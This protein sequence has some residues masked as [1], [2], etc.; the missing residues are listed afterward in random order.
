MATTCGLARAASCLWGSDRYTFLIRKM[1]TSG[2][3]LF[4]FGVDEQ[5]PRDLASDSNSIWLITSE[6]RLKQYS[7]D[8]V[9]IDSIIDFFSSGW[10]LTW[11]NNH[12]WV[13]D[14]L[15]RTIYQIKIPLYQDITPDSVK[16]WIDSENNLV[17]LDVRELYEFESYGRIPH[18]INLPWNSGVLDT[19][20]TQLSVEDTIIVVCR[21]G[22][23]SKQA[24]NFLDGKGFQHVYNMLGGMDAWHYPV[25]AGGHISVDVIWEM[26]KSSFMVASDV[27]VDS[28]K[29]LTLQP[30][31]SM[32]FDGFFSLEVYGTLLAEGTADDSIHFV[33]TGSLRMGWEGIKMFEGSNSSLSYCGMEDSQ[34]GIICLNS[35]PTIL[36]S[37]ISGSQNSLY[38]SGQEATPFVDSC[39]LDG[40]GSGTFILI[41]CDSSSSPT[42]TNC[43]ILG[44]LKGVV[45]K[46]GADPQ[47]N[48]NNI[49][50]NVEYG[51]SNEDSTI[52]VDARYNWW[53]HESGPFDTSV[54]PEG[55]GDRVSLWVDYVPWLNY[56]M[57]YVPGDANRDGEIEVGD[58]VYL[59]SYLYRGDDPPDPLLAGDATCDGDVN[60]DDVVNLIS[61][62][63]RN[64][65]SPSCK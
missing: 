3:E 11:E 35:S 19:A 57:P 1:S 38:F 24:S 29:S 51:I 4:G 8:G 47:V 42:I 25:E 37:S 13:S 40:S 12:L 23:R 54:N 36:N 50:N 26:D 16:N 14:P 28:G 64:G 2:E 62:L 32:Q 65:L 39:L 48:Y 20:Y 7:T 49:Y 6:G 15:S 52:V 30:G 33:S 44:G 5:N 34:D 45:T 18:A 27:I 55:Q 43:L 59:I 58:V 60:V 17:I 22:N 31:I 41:L 53:G 21:S 9:V 46:N 63:F 61:Y 10:G 56:P